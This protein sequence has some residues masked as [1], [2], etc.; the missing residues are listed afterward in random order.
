[1]EEENKK[2]DVEIEVGLDLFGFKTSIKAKTDSSTSKQILSSFLDDIT[3]NIDKVKK[4]NEKLS[5]IQE[6]IPEKPKIQQS[7]KI[8]VHKAITSSE[9]PLQR[10][11]DDLNTNIERISDSK[12]V[13]FKPGVDKPQIIGASRFSPENG[14]L[15]ILYS[16]EIGLKKHFVS[17]EEANEVYEDC[18]YKVGS[19]AARTIPVL[20]Q[21]DLIDKKK[22]ESSK[23][24]TL[25]PKG[26]ETARRLFKKELGIG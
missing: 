26:L 9:E 1:M 12:I 8:S 17:S 21:R 14:A 22:Y 4:I 23:E 15:I 11:A 5:A 2:C 7:E 25:S 20:K 18:H 19:I 16:F 6:I 24:L 10:I 3:S 13:A